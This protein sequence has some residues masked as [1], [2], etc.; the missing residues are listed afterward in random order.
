MG[1]MA[2]ARIYQ[3]AIK[4]MAGSRRT[5]VIAWRPPILPQMRI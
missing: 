5:I 4:A 2:M 1:L 3:S